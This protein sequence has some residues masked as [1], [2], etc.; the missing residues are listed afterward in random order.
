MTRACVRKPRGD[1]VS[2]DNEPV[3]DL[4]E[5]VGGSQGKAVC[6]AGTRNI[7]F[8]PSSSPIDA[9]RPCCTRAR[10]WLLVPA[11]L[12]APLLAS[13]QRPANGTL[14]SNREIPTVA[15]RIG[16]ECVSRRSVAGSDYVDG[17]TASTDQ[18]RS[19]DAIIPASQESVRQR[20]HD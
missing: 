8:D 6:H 15:G 1:V 3:I 19:I 2:S 12:F 11:S 20:G 9:R 13:R 4:S 16:R 5:P 14:P 18:A 10:R 7:P 17:H